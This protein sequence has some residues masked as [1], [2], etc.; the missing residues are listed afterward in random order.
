MPLNITQV[1]QTNISLPYFSQGLAFTSE[2]NIVIARWS[3]SEA[4]VYSPELI[5]QYGVSLTGASW[6]FGL[7]S[8]DNAI[9]LVD[10]SARGI[11]VVLN[12]GRDYSHKISVSWE[13]LHASIN[14]ENLYVPDESGNRVYKITLDGN[15]IQISTDV[16][17]S[18]FLDIPHD[19]YVDTDRIAVG[20]HGGSKLLSVF[21]NDA[22]YSL[23]WQFPVPGNPRGVARD[24]HQHYLVAD[25]FGQC[26]KLISKDGQFLENIVE[27]ISGAPH[28]IIQRGNTVYL[29]AYGSPHI[30][31]RF[32]FN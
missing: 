13:P 20:N 29:T 15:Y 17:I 31:Y 23:E 2:N 7:T 3:K 1:T 28:A 21:L 9:F 14:G 11:H 4:D 22:A 18:S 19:L 6:L 16:I 26:I 12:D 27:G 32:V 8:Q 10:Y 5:H 24:N 30:L 25:Q